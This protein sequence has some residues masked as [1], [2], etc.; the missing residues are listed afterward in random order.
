MFPATFAI[1]L[2]I[3]IILLIM[4][5]VIDH[6]VAALIGGVIAIFYMAAIWPQWRLLILATDPGHIYSTLP[7]TFDAHVFAYLF[8]KWVDLPTLIIILSMLVITEIA[9]DAGVFQ[10]IAIRAIKFSQGDTKKLLLIFCG[11]SFAMTTVLTQITTMLI[12]GAL[13]FL[14]C[15]ALEISPA[16]F[17][18]SIAMV[19]NVG[20]TTSLIASVPAMLIAGATLYSFQWFIINM[21]PLGLILLLV[22]LITV[23]WL[24]RKDLITPRQARIEDLLEI[25]PWEMVPNRMVFYRTAILLVGIIVGFIIFGSAGLTFLVALAGALIFV[26]LSGIRPG[27]VFKEIDW[28]A[29]FFFIGLFI[30]VGLL[31]EFYVLETIGHGIL[32]LT[33]GNPLIATVLMIWISGLTSGF[34]DN[35]PVTLTFIPVVRILG[36]GPPPLPQGNLWASL[37]AGAVLGGCLTPIASAANV[38]ATTIAEKE[39]RPLPRS[40]FFITG[41]VLTI[42]YLGVST[43]YLFIR[44]FIFPIPPPL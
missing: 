37:L 15:D 8:G 5:D 44:L 32:T 36:V 30:L 41:L 17:L 11:L 25:D 12:M 10:F 20:G 33:M 13:A 35:I 4:M 31:E 34:V 28:T 38:L 7:A 19:S 6:T 27:Q 26:I 39:D 29:L 21:M 16:P 3:A 1:L 9:K 14:T 18:I 23:R 40:R 24:F 43:I 22:T 42:L 2:F